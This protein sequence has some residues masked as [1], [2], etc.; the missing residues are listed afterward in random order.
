[1]KY[2]DYFEIKNV[3]ELKDFLA[4]NPGKKRPFSFG[5]GKKDFFMIRFKMT[6]QYGRMS[7][8]YK[9]VGFSTDL[10]GEKIVGLAFRKVE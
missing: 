7:R 4:K 8:A 9:C 1:M 2:P 5:R 10:N 6:N 3:D